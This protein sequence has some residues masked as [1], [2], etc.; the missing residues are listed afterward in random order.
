[1]G[2]QTLYDF[3]IMPGGIGIAF[4]FLYMQG[5][6]TQKLLEKHEKDCD[7]WHVQQTATNTKLET[8]VVQCLQ[9]IARLEGNPLPEKAK[10]DA[11]VHGK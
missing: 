2:F 1:M 6:Q 3:I 10:P 11:T 5:R 7:K 9:G 4:V 8:W